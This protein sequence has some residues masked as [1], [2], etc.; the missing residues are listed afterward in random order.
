MGLRNDAVSACFHALHVTARR[1]DGRLREHAQEAL[2]HFQSTLNLLPMT[3]DDQT[4]N[5]P[6]ARAPF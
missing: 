3:D 2:T 6:A 4:E 5:L 1:R